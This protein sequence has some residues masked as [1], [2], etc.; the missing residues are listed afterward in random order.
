MAL[1]K[2]QCLFQRFD[3]LEFRLCAYI[4]NYSRTLHIRSFFKT[5]SRLGDGIF[6]YILILSL[7]FF[8]G[9]EGITQMFLVS[10]TG[11]ISVCIY[12][13][14]K[15]HL[16]RERPYISFG[17]I[18]AHT[19]ALDKYS[20]PSGHS[21]NAACLALFLGGC[22]V[23]L[24]EVVAVFAGFVA[25]SRVILGMHYPSDVV[26]GLLLGCCVAYTGLAILPFPI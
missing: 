4:N 10:I 7:P 12:K 5:I 14:L 8:N 13:L 11:L 3:Q 24:A 25:M 20:F 2:N 18:I 6:W 21:M 1:I 19:Q 9:A 15:A 26:V 16:I 17:T 22:E 23:M